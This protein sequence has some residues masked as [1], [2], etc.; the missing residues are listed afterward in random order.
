MAAFVEGDSSIII[1]QQFVQELLEK[2]SASREELERKLSNN[3]SRKIQLEHD[4]NLYEYCELWSCVSK[5]LDDECL[6]FW[7]KS[8]PFGTSRVISNSLKFMPN[9]KAVI[10][11]LSEFYGLFKGEPIYQLEEVQ[12]VARIHLN[13]KAK[14]P[15]RIFML[16]MV[17]KC[18][19]HVCKT[20]YQ[21]QRVGMSHFFDR[22]SSLLESIF[23]TKNIVSGETDYIEFHNK[24][25][26]LPVY[27]LNI[28]I[29]DESFFTLA[30]LSIHKND[31]ENKIKT[32]LRDQPILKFPG[33]KE[34][35]NALGISEQIL[36]RRL[37]DVDTSYQK[38]KDNIRKDRAI[39]LLMNAEL[40]IKEIAYQVGFDE[41]ASF[42]KAF[43]KWCALSP[44]D[45]RDHLLNE[46]P[47]P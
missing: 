33:K 8:V 13:F 12:G 41:P 11:W 40:S 43:K 26:N 42:N 35:A 3:T 16:A 2:C 27:P 23:S 6:G 1:D 39:V 32:I 17:Y 37:A 28:E 4:L 31:L 21:I 30:L 22:Y 25:L 15:L 24:V 45:Y 9:A 36:S 5:E 14:S 19:C 20:N 10:L 44:S 38:I 47:K 34:L 29:E 7:K 18:L 46:N